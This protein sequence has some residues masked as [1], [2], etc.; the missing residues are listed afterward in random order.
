MSDPTPWPSMPTEGELI[1]D[2][3]TLKLYVGARTDV[4]DD[5]LTQRLSAATEWVYERTMQCRWGHADV[6][7]AI[8]LLASRLYKRRQSPEGIAG[9]ASEGFVVRITRV[10]PDVMLLI[11]RHLD[12]YNVGVG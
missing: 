4:D 12:T 5:L 11:E 6:Q 9:F 1:A 2:L 10:D 8:L 3:T 7:E